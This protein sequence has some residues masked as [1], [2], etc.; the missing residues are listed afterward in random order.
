MTGVDTQVAKS[1]PTSVG[2]VLTIDLGAL[3]ANYRK[4]QQLSGK[5]ECAAVVKAN[6]YG[7]GDREVVRALV[8]AGCKTLFVA[9][10]KE[11]ARVRRTS[12]KPDIYVLDG[13]QLYH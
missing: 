5:A 3:I 4:M 12:R 13:F 10:L 6:A 2:A 9:N 1:V 11:A 7:L 8:K